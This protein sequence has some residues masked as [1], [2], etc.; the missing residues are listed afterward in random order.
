LVPE[1]D[2]AACSTGSDL[3]S[4][5]LSSLDSSFFSSTA[6]AW[7]EG[8]SAVSLPFQPFTETSGKRGTYA[9]FS[10]FGSSFSASLEVSYSSAC[11]LQQSGGLTLTGSGAAAADSVSAAVSVEVPPREALVD[12]AFS[13]A[14]LKRFASGC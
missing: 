4:T 11:L 12:W 8:A 10:S 13:K 14:S 7:V 1:E 9:T 3:V 6:G 5:L 2:S